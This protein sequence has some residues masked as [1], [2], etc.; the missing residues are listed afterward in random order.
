[1]VEEWILRRCTLAIAILSRLVENPHNQNP[2]M[3]CDSKTRLKGPFQREFDLP[4]LQSVQLQSHAR[5][6][7]IIE[8]VARHHRPGRHSRKACPPR[9][10][11]VSIASYA[12]KWNC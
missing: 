9:Y 1:M 6:P 4:Q 2:A 3:R 5:F 10:P 12:A 11:L 8:R 7:S